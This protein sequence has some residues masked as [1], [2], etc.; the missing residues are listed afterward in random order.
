MHMT[1]EHYRCVNGHRKLKS[2]SHATGLSCKAYYIGCLPAS[3]T[4]KASWQNTEHVAC[5][6]GYLPSYA[7][8]AGKDEVRLVAVAAIVLLKLVQVGTQQLTD[9]KEVLLHTKLPSAGGTYT[10]MSWMQYM[11]CLA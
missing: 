4:V 2:G 1:L 3:S 5:T 11:H 6:Q 7:L 9:Q 8:H 10:R